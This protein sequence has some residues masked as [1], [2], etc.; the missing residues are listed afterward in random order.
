MR[1]AFNK[2]LCQYGN[3]LGHEQG[4]VNKIQRRRLCDLLIPIYMVA[5]TLVVTQVTP[6]T[7]FYYFFTMYLYTYARTYCPIIKEHL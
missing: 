3:T 1:K 7:M 6:F 5:T 4:I 2:D